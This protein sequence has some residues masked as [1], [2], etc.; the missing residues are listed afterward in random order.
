M[1]HIVLADSY[2]EDPA[3]ALLGI[4]WQAK[5]GEH[6]EYDHGLPHV[7]LRRNEHARIRLTDFVVLIRHFLLGRLEAAYCLSKKK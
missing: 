6:E 5:Q 1:Q 3:A 2:D 7:Q 4:R